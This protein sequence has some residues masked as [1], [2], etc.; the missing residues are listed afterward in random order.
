MA[1]WLTEGNF[2]AATLNAI[3]QFIVPPPKYMVDRLVPG[4]QFQ[5]RAQLALIAV[6]ERG[7][8]CVADL[9]ERKKVDT[10]LAN[11][12]DAYGF[13]PY[14]AIANALSNWNGEDLHLKEREVVAAAINLLPAVQIASPRYDWYKTLPTRLQ[15]LEPRQP[16]ALV[17]A[18]QA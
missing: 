15:A 12:E 11:A 10:L 1:M 13:P 8:D 3:V 2:P 16:V 17:P 6:I 14:P 7:P 4:A 18:V 5:K 9:D